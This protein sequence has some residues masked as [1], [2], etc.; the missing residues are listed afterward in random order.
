MNKKGD[1]DDDSLQ[2][3]QQVSKQ[4]DQW[5]NTRGAWGK[6]GTVLWTDRAA[7]DKNAG[8][9]MLGGQSLGQSGTAKTQAPPPPQTLLHVPGNNKVSSGAGSPNM[10]TTGHTTQVSPTLPG[11]HQPVWGFRGLAG[12]WP[13]SATLKMPQNNG[14]SK[15]VFTLHGERYSKNTFNI[16]GKELED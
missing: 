12:A 11:T 9:G 4:W 15:L 1:G 3:W 13:T 6:H 10:T 7:D 14:S 2:P 16:Q 5:Y 8:W